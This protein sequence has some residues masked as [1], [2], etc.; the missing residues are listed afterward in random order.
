MIDLKLVRFFADYRH[1]FTDGLCLNVEGEM[2]AWGKGDRGQLGNDAIE[3]E[4]HTGVPITKAVVMND[5]YTSKVDYCSLG[6]ISQI[7]SG[8]IHSAALE[9]DTN[10]V[11]TWG[12]HVLPFQLDEALRSQSQS[13]WNFPWLPAVKKVASDARVPVRVFGLPSNLKV[14]Q[15]ACGSHHT[16]ALLEDGSVWAVGIATDTKK[17]IH[18]AKCIVEAG[19]I[20]LETISQFTAH[21]D[22]TT[23]VFDGQVVQVHLWD[24]PELQ[25]AGVF[26]P[27]WANQL[28]VHDPTVRIRE[29]HRSWLHSAIV[30][31]VAPL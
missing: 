9:E 7:S 3:T 22:R 10:F 28:L 12:K 29:V 6:K 30:T 27:T 5:D 13:F 11:Y 16:A 17:P 14:R 19:I 8:L 4:S 23:I 25:S 20:D 15:I 26:S 31:E 18:E 1:A 21:M 2:F 24:D